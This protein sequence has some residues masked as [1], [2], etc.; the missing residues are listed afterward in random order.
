[1]GDSKKA[2]KT[3]KFVLTPSTRPQKR[4]K[5]NESPKSGSNAR[6][7]FVPEQTDHQR[8]GSIISSTLQAAAP[9]NIT[10]PP[11]ET[12]PP[13]LAHLQHKYA[14]ATMTFSSSSKINQKVRA[15]I[16]RMEKFSFADLNAKPGVVI[17]QAKAPV[18]VKMVS[19]VEIAKREIEK[20]KGKWWQYSKVEGRLE[21]LKERV[22]KKNDTK[23][24]G[25][26]LKE[27]QA[28]QKSE[29][30]EG[31]DAMEEVVDEAEAAPK[32]K[33]Q[34]AASAEEDEDDE[35]FQTMA[36]VGDTGKGAS[37]PGR[38]K[39]RAIPIM[40]ICMARVPVPELKESYGEQTNA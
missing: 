31:G 8:L 28:E 33:V 27:W 32:L 22:K 38:P 1:M 6:V 15:L 40:T 4:V 25:K 10:I 35:A 20:E 5:T 26:T 7:V 23:G 39:V 3:P 9:P 37:A 12:L 13:A 17:L 11:P 19:V 29:T 36:D 14:L 24:E 16:S 30:N 2:S 18:A 21:E 34:T